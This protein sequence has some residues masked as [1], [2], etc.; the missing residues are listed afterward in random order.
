V[1]ALVGLNIRTGPSTGYAVIGILPANESARIIGRDEFSNWWQIEYLSD[2]GDRGW[3]AAGGQFSTATNVETVPVVQA[4]PLETVAPT[5]T[6]TGPPPTPTP[7]TLKPTIYSFTADRYSINAGDSVVLTW[8]LANAKVAYLRYGDVE[9]GVPAPSSKTFSLDEDTKFIL[10]ARN[11]AGETT[12]ELTVKVTGPTPTSV[13]VWRDGKVRIASG[14]YVDF[15]Q[16]FVQS[17]SGGGVDFYWDGQQQ[18]FFPQDGAAGVLLSR[19]YDEI[20]L[21]D[22]RA[23]SYGQP[24]VGVDGSTQVKGCYITNEGRYGKFLISEWDLAANLTIQWLT[25]DYRQ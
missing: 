13:P 2:S 12:A 9:E 14:Q 11:D 4:P 19:S 22:C 18:Q 1:T 15:D 10:I 5:P 8:D 16:G 25:W 21:D 20:T 24:I 17:E 7:D 6:P 23:V 3:V